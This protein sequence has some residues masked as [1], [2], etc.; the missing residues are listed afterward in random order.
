MLCS[1]LLE[2]LMMTNKFEMIVHRGARLPHVNLHMCDD[3]SRPAVSLRPVWDGVC[4]LS[5]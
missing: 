4:H 5:G 3:L 2:A 1:M